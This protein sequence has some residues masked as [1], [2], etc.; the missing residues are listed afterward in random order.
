MLYKG[1]GDRRGCLVRDCDRNR[2]T[3][4]DAREGDH[5]GMARNGEWE[6]PH[7][8][9]RNQLIGAVSP[10]LAFGSCSLGGRV[11]FSTRD[12]ITK[13]S[14]DVGTDGVPVKLR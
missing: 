14:F 2:E 10:K 9:G 11:P 12:T 3:G 6:G 5:V 8:I 13:E 1:A 4:E 7:D